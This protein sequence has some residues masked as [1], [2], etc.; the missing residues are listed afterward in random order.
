MFKKAIMFAG[1]ALIIFFSA[2]PAAAQSAPRLI[3]D[4]E[5]ESTLHT[6]SRPVFE[7]AGI[8]PQTVRFILVEDD[9]L[10]AFVAGG[11]N[12]FIHTGLILK[13]ANPEELIGVIAHETGHIALGHLFRLG[14]NVE[15]L[16]LQALLSNILGVAVAVGTGSGEAGMAVSSAGQTMALRNI[17]SHTRTQESS[18]DEA[19][20][21]FL[22]SAGMTTEGLL[23]FMQ[24]LADQ[25]LLPESQQSRYV[26]THPLTQDRIDFLKHVTEEQGPAN[27]ASPALVSLHSRMKA[28]L[29]GYLYPDRALQ[30][31]SNTPDA[32][33]A[34]AIALYRK[35]QTEKSISILEPLIKQ[36]PQNP[37][38]HELKGQI[39]FEGGKV[40]AAL[41]AYIKALEGA[42]NSSLI[43]TAYAHAL[44][45]KKPSSPQTLE[46]AIKELQKSLSKDPRQVGA[47]RFM[48]IAYG[49]LKN[50]GMMR[51]HLSESYLL[52]NKLDFAKKEA[53]L[54]QKT[55]PAK[56]AAAQR[57]EDILDLVEKKQK[58]KKKD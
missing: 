22:R 17:L 1:I 51:L 10:N 54:A 29:Q 37:Y 14:E 38:L 20:V 39:L 55:I 47:H 7:Q 19:G 57:V 5:I 45:E 36:E 34:R 32:Q 24:K 26:R 48:A 6:L 58:N 49:K 31:K 18:A 30:D 41:P 8:S 21:R 46:T 43:R 53:L 4:E 35:G 16:S 15:N 9:A 50:D 3:R 11:Q 13:T 23:S 52:Q 27:K 2:A 33:Y 12:I 56:T 28:K 40:D 44:L 25:E 42:P